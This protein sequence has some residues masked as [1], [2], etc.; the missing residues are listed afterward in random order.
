MPLASNCPQTDICTANTAMVLSMLHI[1]SIITMRF[2]KKIFNCHW[3]HFKL[4]KND[5]NFNNFYFKM[6]INKNN[7]LELL[8]IIKMLTKDEFFHVNY[9]YSRIFI[10]IKI[11]LIPR[12]A[13]FKKGKKKMKV[14]Q[15]VNTSAINIK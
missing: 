11:L 12:C 2:F 14:V 7:I 15:Y 1:I 5:F 6:R 3:N 10:D 8:L 4:L 13:Q 9:V